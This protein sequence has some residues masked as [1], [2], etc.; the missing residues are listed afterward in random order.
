MPVTDISE[1]ETTTAVEID[2]ISATTED[3]LTVT[4]S[5]VD[6]A[7]PDTEASTVQYPDPENLTT[8]FISIAVT[9]I[10]DSITTET[11]APEFI[12]ITSDSVETSTPAETIETTDVSP[13][14]LDSDSLA[15]TKLPD[16]TTTE[17]A[18]TEL[19]V[20]GDFIVET[21]TSVTDKLATTDLV[22]SEVETSTSVTDTLATTTEA[23]STEQ[24]ISTASVAED[25]DTSSVTE[26]ITDITS[27][28]G[29]SEDDFTTILSDVTTYELEKTTT[30]TVEITKS[31]IPVEDE[32][33]GPL[34]V[35]T[36]SS[37]D[38]EVE[39]TTKSESDQ[40]REEPQM[41][42]SIYDLDAAP[43]HVNNSVYYDGEAVPSTVI[44]Q[45]SCRCLNGTVT[46]ERKSCPPNPSQFLRCSPV[47]IYSEDQCC[48]IFSCRKYNFYSNYYH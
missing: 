4:E 48:P 28:A 38:S 20:T 18:I 47:P 1:T 12:S 31:T 9:E 5:A 13:S 21:S 3:S 19:Y 11:A 17:A 24:T 34:E 46:C 33:A 40:D 39:T 35:Y 2:E 37:V 8:E 32:T 29:I 6:E 43:C 26:Q 44:C 7:S 10:P 15:S 30:R 27:A 14:D 16:S 22:P 41:T 45:H 23:G 36:L 25:A 42:T